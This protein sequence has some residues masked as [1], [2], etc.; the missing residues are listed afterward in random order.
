M[1]AA[2]AAAYLST[3]AKLQGI[4]QAKLD[5][6]TGAGPRYLWRV[7]SGEIEKP[8]AAT[9]LAIAQHVRAELRELQA[10]LLDGDADVGSGRALA[11][12][13]AIRRGLVTHEDARILENASREE[14]RAAIEYLSGFVDRE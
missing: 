1:S 8:A 14:L 13:S 3:L 2:A 4:S 11:L 7:Q 9:L 12:A 10:T 6:L 5:R